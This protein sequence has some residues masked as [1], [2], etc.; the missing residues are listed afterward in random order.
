MSIYQSRFGELVW[1]LWC[2]ETAFISVGLILFILLFVLEKRSPRVAHAHVHG[3]RSIFEP[4]F[5]LQTRFVLGACE[6]IRDGYEKFKNVPF[7][8]RRFD[9]DYS[10]LPMRYLEEIRLIPMTKLSGKESQIRNMMPKWT[11]LEFMVRS[12]LHVD[13]L[14]RKLTPELGRYLEAARSELEY[15]WEVDVPRPDDWLEVDI[16]QITRMLIARMS[17]KVFLG[18]P[19]CRDLDWLQTSVQYSIDTFTTAFILRMFPPFLHF[20]VAQFLP[21]KWRMRAQLRTAERTV[22]PLMEKHAEATRRRSLGEEVEEQEDTLMKWMLENGTEQETRLSEMAA[23]QCVLTLA[24]IHTTATI[25]ANVIFELCARLEWVPVLRDE[26]DR[27]TRE[28]GQP[29]SDPNIDM[30]RWHPRLEK[31]DSFIV[32]TFRYYPPILLGP[33]RL[34]LEDIT[35]KDG[36]KIPTGAKIAFAMYHHQNDAAVTPGP[37]LFDPMRSYRK[38]Q[39]SAE[40]YARYQAT[41]P[42]VNNNLSFG[43]GNQACPGRFFAIAEIKLVISRLLNEFDFRLPEGQCRPKIMYAD[44][45]TFIDPNARI[46]MRKRRIA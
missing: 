20:I 43:Y 35:L 40:E 6:I 4:P 7:I 16:Q 9:A 34:A 22:R 31:L 42:D 45:N 27:V 2:L 18:H 23:R 8:V 46:M 14:K 5:F 33:Q 29:G 37:G 38:R 25:V 12:H 30:R 36:T 1:S 32:E 41:L 28:V 26:F 24:S 21:S 15:G 19:A 17:A 11:G 39:S 10:V 44:E 3:Y 13:V